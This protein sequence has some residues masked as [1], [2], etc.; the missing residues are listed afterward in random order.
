MD[1]TRLDR[2]LLLLDEAE[3]L[4]GKFTGGYSNRFIGAEEFHH[5]LTD[6]IAKLRAGD[7]SEIDT[8]SLY[9]TPTCSWDDFT[10][11]DGME[12]GNEIYELL[13]GMRS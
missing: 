3:A 11:M 2:L 9:F 1:E 6:S 10:G 8:L 4:A 12:L 13:Q 7:R 5:E